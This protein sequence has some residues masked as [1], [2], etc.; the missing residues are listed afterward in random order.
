MGQAVSARLEGRTDMNVV[1][2]V[3]L[4]PGIQN[5]YPVYG[6]FDDITEDADVAVD[7]SH[8]S[9]TPAL[10]DFCTKK[11]LP[12]VLCTTGITGDLEAQ[13]GEAAKVIPLFK[14]PN[15]SLGVSLLLSL[16]RLAAGVLGD[17]CDIEIIEKH[18]NKKV[19]APSGTAMMIADAVSSALPYDPR[20]VYDRSAVHRQRDRQEIGLHAIRGGAIVGEHEVMFISPNETLTVSHSALSRELFTDGVVKA[21]AFLTKN[22]VPRIYDMD[23]L[24]RSLS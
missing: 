8:I 2:G 14:S 19:D 3:D 22:T 21:I 11:K 9:L 15:M 4:K 6:D 20:Y 5:G 23:D 12:L 1:A 18:H 16:V 13:V 7:F 17:S 10:L 24:V